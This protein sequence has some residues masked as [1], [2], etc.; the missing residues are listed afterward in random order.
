MIQKM[1]PAG[2][3][4]DPRSHFTLQ[5]YFNSLMRA[6][7]DMEKVVVSFSKPASNYTKSSR[8]YYGYVSEEDLGEKCRMTF[9]VAH[10]R[11]F[12]R[13][14]MMYGT[15]VEI[16]HPAALRETM[17]EL[18]EELAAHY[19]SGSV[20]PGILSQSGKQHV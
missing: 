9:L 10:T 1:N 19:S 5:E 17:E 6:H 12:C 8:Y 15:A 13:W 16:E 3:T 7:E 20:L 14:L 2:Q 11:S 18:V 4:F